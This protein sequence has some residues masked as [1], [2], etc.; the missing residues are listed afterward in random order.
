MKPVKLMECERASGPEAASP[1]PAPR[2]VYLEPAV[3]LGRVTGREGALWRVAVG[4]RE[5]LL[6]LD[7]S[8]DPA[9]VEQA[10]RTGARVVVDAAGEPCVAGVLLVQRALTVTREG[11]VEARVRRFRVRAE[12]EAVLATARSFVRVVGDEA[13]IYG[14]R[15]IARAR[16]VAKILGRLIALN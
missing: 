15:V 10:W 16:E 2:V 8:V 13:E 14:Q 1:A 11:D 5:R 7:P 12:D 3:Q 9:L 4:A 6:P